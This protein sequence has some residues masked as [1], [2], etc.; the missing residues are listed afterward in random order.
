MRNFHKI[1]QHYCGSPYKTRE[2]LIRDIK[3]N[4]PYEHVAATII[5]VT[6]VYPAL[7]LRV[8][9][10]HLFL[11]FRYLSNLKVR[12]NHINALIEHL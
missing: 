3:I 7:T 4:K 6:A 2:V 10:V 5:V 8:H 11:T 9:L 12:I 1:L